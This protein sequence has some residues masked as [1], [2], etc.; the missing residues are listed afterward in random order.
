M[1][2]GSIKQDAG[3]GKTRYALVSEADQIVAMKEDVD[4]TATVRLGLRWLPCPYVAH[5]QFDAGTHAL[6]GPTY[7]V[8]LTEVIE[9]LGTVAK[10]AE[11][12]STEK[13]VT[14]SSIMPALLKVLL[15][16]ENRI[17]ALAGQGA[18]TM[19]QFKNALKALL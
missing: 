4:L 8:T 1:K 11:Q 7:S 14:V 15:N 12:I 10:T 16:H 2:P 17:R 19:D 9:A 5:P 3:S 13:E 18:V 6:T